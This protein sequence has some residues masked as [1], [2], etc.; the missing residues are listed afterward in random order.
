MGQPVI[1]FE[2]TGK[3]GDNLVRFYSELFG[4]EI[5]A[6]N[7]LKYGVVSREGN[8]NADGVGIGGGVGA[9][10]PESPGSVTFYVEVPD[11]AATFEQAESLGGAKVYGPAPVPGTDVVLGQF[12][13][14]EGRV[15]GL[16]QGGQ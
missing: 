14:P 13:D 2:V 3:D 9:A 6:D 12:T 7:P 10:Q 8:T 5:D 1:H 11:I 16:M 4:W 15:I